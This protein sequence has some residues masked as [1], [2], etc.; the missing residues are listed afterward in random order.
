MA[1]LDTKLGH[2]EKSLKGTVSEEDQ[3]GQRGERGVRRREGKH[4]NIS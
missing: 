4:V 2:A 3:G 1:M